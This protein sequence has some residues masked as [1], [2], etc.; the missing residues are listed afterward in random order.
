MG[1][2]GSYA[3]FLPVHSLYQIVSIKFG[4]NSRE[5]YGS[6]QG[7][8]SETAETRQRERPIKPVR[9]EGPF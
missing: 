1:L 3:Y 9:P 8:Y 6:D 4:Y 7:I 2:T 5:E